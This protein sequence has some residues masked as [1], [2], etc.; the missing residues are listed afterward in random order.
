MA[1]MLLLPLIPLTVVIGLYE[2]FAIHSD[3]NF[4]GSHWFGHGLGTLL[5]IAIGLFITMNTEYF[6]QVANITYEFPLVGSVWG[7]RIL[8]GIILN[9]KIHAQSSIARG[10]GRIA[11][12]GLSEHWTH[13]LIVS[14]LVIFAPL[15]WPLLEGFLPG[16]LGGSA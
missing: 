14:L 13:T 10:G 11:A 12:R 4:R 8:T 9:F 7:I 2:L 6:I 3:M 1:E 15:F 16:Y 5:P